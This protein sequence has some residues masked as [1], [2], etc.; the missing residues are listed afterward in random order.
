[1]ATVVVGLTAAQGNYWVVPS[2]CYGTIQIECIGP[3]ANADN[4]YQGGQGG[5]GGAYAKGNVTLSAPTGTR[6]AYLNWAAD[7]W[8]NFQTNAAPTTAN[9]TT[10]GVKAAGGI[11]GG[12]GGGTASCVPNTGAF[13]GGA[14]NGASSGGAAGPNGAGGA[15]NG[16]RGGSANGGQWPGAD[17][18]ADTS[19]QVKYTDFFG[20]TYGPSNGSG[21]GYSGG[22]FKDTF[23]AGPKPASNYGGG[24]PG[25]GS[26]G[27]I[28]ITYTSQTT[29]Q[30]RYVVPI[31]K[32]GTVTWRVPDGVTGIKAELIGPGRVPYWW[33]TSVGFTGNVGLYQ[34]ATPGPPFIS[35]SCGGG[36]GAYALNYL[37]VTSNSIMYA[38]IP[39]S[40]TLTDNKTWLNT[41]N[42]IPTSLNTGVTAAG[43]NFAQQY[44][45][46][47]TLIQPGYPY[48]TRSLG[49]SLGGQAK[50]CLAQ[51]AYS[52]GAGGSA[53]DVG[54]L[55]YTDNFKLGSAGG[56]GAAGPNGPGANG[57]NGFYISTSTGRGTDTGA[58]GGS[59]GGGAANGGGAGLTSTSTTGG[60]GGTSRLGVLG[61][62]GSVAYDTSAATSGTAGSGGGGGSY[63]RPNNYAYF[64]ISS[65]G[66]IDTT[67]YNT[68][69]A[70]TKGGAGSTEVL[71]Y[72]NPSGVNIYGPGSG[73]GGAGRIWFN[74]VT[75]SNP[76]N[77]Q[78]G[79]VNNAGKYGGGMGMG[80]NRTDPANSGSTTTAHGQPGQGLVII[81]YSITRNPS[82]AFLPMFM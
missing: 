49:F 44:Q 18:G 75:G 47:E 59:G 17:P 73:S 29:T 51:M 4:V 77:N 61:G 15:G 37:K 42:A 20:Q 10:Q 34:L 28:I 65:P 64:Y 22:Y 5:G 31:E 41:T 9:Q 8:I 16:S 60:A 70:Y 81:S 69:F 45:V 36:G 46:V 23:T 32:T 35:M 38:N 66:N 78:I 56:G 7:T 58:N 2:D 79:Y 12:A 63:F 74:N 30:G 68:V 1:M 26:N 55:T 67:Y 19:M 21:S 52:G 25:A 14:S 54:S 13:A 48:I 72:W 6:V 62:S 39:S 71:P 40:S 33:S 50:D 57:G 82:S 11:K 80:T 76:E 53:Y 27:L 24:G 43:G 3:G